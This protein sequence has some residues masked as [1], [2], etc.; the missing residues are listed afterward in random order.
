MTEIWAVRIERTLT[1]EQEQFAIGL[2]PSERW[3]RMKKNARPVQAPL[4]AYA[5]L[6]LALWKTA[7][8]KNWPDIALS[9]GG[10]PFF[11]G[12]PE[13][14][15]NLSH[16]DGAVLAGVSSQC[17]GVDI[18]KIR[19]MKPAA[20]RRLADETDPDAFF[21]SWVCRE[22]L[23]KRDG[24]GFRALMEK[25]R[26]E[27]PFYRGFTPFPGYAAGAA[28]CGGAEFALHC[29]TVDALLAELTKIL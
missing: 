25:S 10:K 18:E 21:Q 29:C 7:G 17:L 27:D 22:S 19:P 28:M 9:E 23:A 1:P 11:P 14:Q 16:T 12:N 4:C 13:I 20:M 24:A 3:G 5:A 8:L 6:R 26:P 2:L 15:F